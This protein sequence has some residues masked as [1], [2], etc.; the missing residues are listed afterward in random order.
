MTG[1]SSRFSDDVRPGTMYEM[2]S[3]RIVGVASSRPEYPATY[4]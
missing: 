1:A 2:I 4:V 3:Y